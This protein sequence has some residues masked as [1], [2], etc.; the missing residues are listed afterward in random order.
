M[1]LFLMGA[2][3][4]ETMI[5]MLD[6]EPLRPDAPVQVMGVSD[7]IRLYARSLGVRRGRPIRL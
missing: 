5:C 6:G 7:V 1:A 2:A 4:I 3:W